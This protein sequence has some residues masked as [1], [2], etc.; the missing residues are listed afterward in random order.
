MWVAKRMQSRVRN[1]E[2]QN[3][4]VNLAGLQELIEGGDSYPYF[5]GS[6]KVHLFCSE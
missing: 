3:L 5:M 6:T 4:S 1:P 2:R